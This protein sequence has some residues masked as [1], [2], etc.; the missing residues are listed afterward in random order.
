MVVMSR[1]HEIPKNVKIF[2]HEIE[3]RMGRDQQMPLSTV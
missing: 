2:W 1:Q 3:D